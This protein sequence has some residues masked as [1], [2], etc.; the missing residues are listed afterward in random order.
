MTRKP[1]THEELQAMIPVLESKLQKQ[2][3]LAATNGEELKSIPPLTRDECLEYFFRLLDT[4]SKRPLTLQECGLHG[5]LLA[6]FEQSA[7]ALALGKSGRFYV[8]SEER[9]MQMLAQQ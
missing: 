9:I 7:M 8:I 3:D 2:E 6:Q 4:A 5:Q 1:W